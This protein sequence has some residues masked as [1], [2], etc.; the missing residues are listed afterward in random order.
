MKRPGGMDNKAIQRFHID[1]GRHTCPSEIEAI[2]GGVSCRREN[3]LSCVPKWAHI[4]LACKTFE[5]KEKK[6][7]RNMAARIP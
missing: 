6:G 2:A 4:C 5:G 7:K 3:D 1:D